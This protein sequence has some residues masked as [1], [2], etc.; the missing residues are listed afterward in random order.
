[1]NI[2]LK[3]AL[4]GVLAGVLAVSA[5]GGE[6]AADK[7]AKKIDVVGFSVLKSA[8]EP[9][10]DAFKKTSDGKG[11]TFAPSYGASGDQ[12][13]AVE[14]GQKADYVHFSLAS[15]V[16]RLVDAGLVADDWN[17][18]PTK[19]IITS[20]VVVFVVRKG[21]PDNI[22]TW[23]DLVKPGVDV[24]TPHPGSS[25]SARWNIL[26]AWGHVL[27]EGGSEK[28]A[29]AYTKKLIDHTIKL[30]GSARDATS[31]FIDQNQGDVLLSYENEA[32][33]AKQAGADIDY[34]IP[35]Q[36]LLIENA[37]A[38][39]KDASDVAKK[40]FSFLF[41]EEAQTAYAKTGFRPVG[42]DV[43]T[44][45]EGANDPS[46]PFPAPSE[47]LLTIDGDF[48]GWGEAKD[49]YFDEENGIIIKLL[50]AAGKGAE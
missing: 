31:A 6:S 44:D 21:N 23:E 46:N 28:D 24:I 14:A 49:K 37:G 9:V 36:T 50:N 35:P 38:L 15:D 7:D 2:K 48:G 22:Q 8:N 20:S 5:C 1:M 27:A 39:T 3:G 13:R 30:P 40:F 47:K 25:G 10:F 29:E 45:V 42:V 12:S 16:T 17:T 18:G 19:G 32:I 4:V 34:V 26:A 41:T 11:V 43:Q 33:L